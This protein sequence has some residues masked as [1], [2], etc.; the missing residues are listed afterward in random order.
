MVDVEACRGSQM[1]G[2]ITDH[3]G[4]IAQRPFSLIAHGL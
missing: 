3:C 1:I 4:G 2:P